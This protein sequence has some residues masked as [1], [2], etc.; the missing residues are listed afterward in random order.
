MS[1][2]L[3]WYTARASG[4]VSWG[5]LAASV[6]WGLLLSTRV[7]RVPRRVAWLLDLHRFL[8]AA[9]IVFLAVHL[10][11]ILLDTYVHFTVAN[12]LVPFT[13]TWR[14]GAVAWG[15]AAMYLLVAIELTSLLRSRLPKRIWRSG[16]YLTFPLFVFATIHGL[17]AGTDRHNLALRATFFGVS[18]LVVALALARATSS[19][20]LRGRPAGARTAP[21]RTGQHLG[22]R[23]P[24]SSRVA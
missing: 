6:V 12:L 10:T 24:S 20:A 22:G 8:G 18:G 5:L 11:T 7:V 13:G 2:T 17:T 4:L 14:P 1:S 9:A 21:A 15:I 19:R 23:S 16:H 3:V